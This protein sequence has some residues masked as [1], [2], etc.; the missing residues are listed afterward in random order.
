MLTDNSY[1]RF[2]YIL[3]RPEGSEGYTVEQ[4]VFDRRTDEPAAE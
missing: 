4:R 1:G 3:Y 2:K